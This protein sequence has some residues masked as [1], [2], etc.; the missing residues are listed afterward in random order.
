MT[1]V[2]TLRDAFR[3]EPPEVNRQRE[4]LNAAADMGSERVERYAIYAD[5]YDGDHYTQVL[6]RAKEYLEASGLRFSENFCELV[7][8]AHTSRLRLTGFTVKTAAGEDGPATGW[9]EDW[10]DRPEQPAIQTTVHNRTLTLGD[11]FVIVEWDA[12][13][14]RAKACWNDPAHCKA[15]YDPEDNDR[16]LYVSKTWPTTRM[17]PTNPTGLKIRRLN[18]YWPDRVEKYFAVDD[19]D[20]ADW[21]PH[22]DAEDTDGNGNA[23]WPIHWT[24]GGVPGGEPLGINV[25]HFRHKP[26]GNAVGRSIL[27]NVI[28]QQD[29]LSKQILDLFYVTDTQAW[30]QRWAT[31]LKEDQRLRVAAGEWVTTANENAKIGELS[32]EDPTPLVATIE[33]T[34]RRISARSRTPLHELLK[35]TAP[36]GEERK[37]ADS[38]IVAATLE[39]HGDF[40]NSWAQVARVA[41]TLATEFGEGAPVIA[42]DAVIEAVWDDPNARNEKEEADT[43]AIHHSLGVSKATLMRKLGY[44]PE[45][46]AKRR[47]EEAAAASSAMAAAFKA[48]GG[49]PIDNRDDEEEE[50]DDGGDQ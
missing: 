48:G 8:D 37:M 18:L 14:G 36:S 39:R 44:D 22:R 27:R 4:F 7:S 13:Q 16:L 19:S 5:Y 49:F 42:P 24:V 3:G 47:Q 6:D 25:V 12:E 31:G 15:V 21:H 38:G 26:L 40:G 29:G 9:L 30:K 33:A 43:F 1:V 20:D 23:T 41:H 50:D 2:N 32:A 28:P 11:G 46:E 45:E 35:S 10:W 17:S 34:L